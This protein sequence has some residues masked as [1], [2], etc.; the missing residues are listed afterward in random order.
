MTFSVDD[1][2]AA[3]GAGIMDEK[4]A[5][6]LIALAQTRNDTRG[7]L[8]DEDEPFEFFRGFSEIFVTVGL[9]LLMGGLVGAFSVVGE[10]VLISVFGAVI[11]VI[12]AR[13]FTLRRRMSLPSIGLAAA[14][15][16]FWAITAAMLIDT[17][18]DGLT[19]LIISLS[20]MIAM[21]LYFRTFKLPF[22]MF[23]CGVFGLVAC[24]SLASIISGNE[25]WDG[26]FWESLF[27][28]SN[29]SG[30]G[31]ASLIFGILSFVGGMYFDLK[32]P[33][34]LSRYSA[35]GFW[36]HLL[37]APALVNTVAF[38]PYNMGSSLG[39]LLTAIALAVISV[40]ALVID[41]RSFLTAGIIYFAI[42]IG[43]ALKEGIGGDLVPVF[44]TLIVGAFVTALGTWWV[45]IRARLM[46]AMPDFA[47][48]NRL[49]PYTEMS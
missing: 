37:A 20:G 43:L 19:S 14:F 17:G 44:A 29:N 40:L 2:R 45:Q 42:L 31:F 9:V 5:S 49:P 48:K 11:C 13:Y 10:S 24:F 3:V 33:N 32:D 34:R 21:S 26:D 6:G 35:T 8:P 18:N 16:G 25:I 4:Q 22:S 30:F 12:F 1:V 28:L 39:Y 36:L 47:G 23:V 7:V 38:S 15:A 41:R 27:D 46:D